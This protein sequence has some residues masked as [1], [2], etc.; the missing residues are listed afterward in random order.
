MPKLQPIEILP[1]EVSV[2]FD[3]ADLGDERLN[4]RVRKIAGTLA[5]TPEGTF[6]HLASDP[7]ELEA[8]YRFLGNESVSWSDVLAPHSACT[9]V[10]AEEYGEV[11]VL[12][13]SSEFAFA[14]ETRRDGLGDLTQNRQGF[15]GHFSLCVSPFESRMPLGVLGIEAIFRTKKP[16]RSRSQQTLES[17]RKTREEKESSRWERAAIE[18]DRQLGANVRAIHVMDQEADDFEVF[19]A[20]ISRGKRFVIRGNASRVLDAASDMTIEGRLEEQPDRF[21][22]RVPLQAR[23][24]NRSKAAKKAHPPRSERI[25]ELRI[26]SASVVLRRP[27]HSKSEQDSVRLNVVQVF[28]PNPPDGEPPVEWTLL[29]TEPI[30]TKAQLKKIVD[31]YCARWI[32]EEYFKALKTGCAYEKR[33]LESA[34]GL[35][36][37]LAIFAVIAWRLLALRTLARTTPDSPATLLFSTEQI[38]LMRGISLRRPRARLPEGMPTIRDMLLAIAGL[39]GH[40]KQNGEP[41]W[42][43]LGRG[44]DDFL[45]AELGWYAAKMTGEM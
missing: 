21:Y 45:I 1:A 7:S 11:L 38:H 22:G 43:V 8:I 28:E 37:A 10:R 20:L 29:T 24:K 16:K 19:A 44:Y 41:G 9:A 33:Q 35:L 2:E 32:I 26:R 36:N 17:R 39:G 4:R 14:G 30:K 25:A 5:R 34:H 40:L 12:H 27:M 6:P 18:A 42:I 23:S 31:A 13:D 15:I 3:G